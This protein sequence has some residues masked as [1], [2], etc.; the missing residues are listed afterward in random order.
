MAIVDADGQVHFLE[1]NVAPGMTT[2]STL[3]LAMQAAGMDLGFDDADGHAQS[4]GGLLGFLGGI[5]D[6]AARNR[7]PK[8]GEELLGLILVDGHAAAFA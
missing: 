2:T 7:D 5:G 4:L 3:P 8:P 1:V 6:A